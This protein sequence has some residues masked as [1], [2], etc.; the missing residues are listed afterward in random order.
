MSQRSDN[1]DEYGEQG[2]DLLAAVILL[3]TAIAYVIVKLHS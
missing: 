1:S 2:N 3:I